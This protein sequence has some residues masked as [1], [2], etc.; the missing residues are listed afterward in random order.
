MLLYKQMKNLI[1]LFRFIKLSSIRRLLIHFYEVAT[2][3]KAD[4]TSELD[5]LIKKFDIKSFIEVGVHNG[6]NLFKL[7]QLNKTTKFIGIDPYNINAW[8]GYN[9]NDM[10]E[11]FPNDEYEEMFNYVNSKA[12]NSHNVVIQRNYFDKIY[13][14]FDSNSVDM[15][16]I[17]ARHDRKS[18]LNDINIAKKIV[19]HGGIISGHNYSLNWFGVVEAV[20]EAFGSDNIR[21]CND[22]VWYT[23]NS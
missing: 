10:K 6:D 8:H 7:A 21:I 1:R 14:S 9:K 23:F 3:P 17:D 18:V 13:E 16:F 4:R 11:L 2:T 15:I 5:N 20:N 22:E 19:K 12:N